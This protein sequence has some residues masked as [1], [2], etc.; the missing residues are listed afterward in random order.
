MYLFS[1]FHGLCGELPG[2]RKDKTTG[3]NLGREKERERE[4]EEEEGEKIYIT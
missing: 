2:R 1:E 4:R 3:T